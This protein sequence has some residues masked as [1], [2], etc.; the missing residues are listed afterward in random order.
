MAVNI[1]ARTDVDKKNKVNFKT[2][3]KELAIN[4]DKIKY[5]SVLIQVIELIQ[6]KGDNSLVEE[7]KK[8]VIKQ[9]KMKSEQE[10]YHEFGNACLLSR[11]ISQNLLNV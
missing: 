4:L 3:L 1:L 10:A 11:Q 7:L 5:Q 8:H 2:V 6:F 9:V